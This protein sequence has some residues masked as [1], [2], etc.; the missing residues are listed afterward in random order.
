M[1]ESWAI[2]TPN[3]KYDRSR[4]VQK[5][6][7][8]ACIDVNKVGAYGGGGEY[9]VQEGFGWTNGGILRLWSSSVGA[10]GPRVPHLSG[11]RGTAHRDNRHYSRIICYYSRHIIHGGRL[12]LGSIAVALREVLE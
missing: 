10:A 2:I 1:S 9:A 5:P 3:R 12:I 6:R 4:K 8:E 11:N 7:P